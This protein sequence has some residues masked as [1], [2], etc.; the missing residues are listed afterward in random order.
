MKCSKL[1]I[2]LVSL[3]IYGFASADKAK[4]GTWSNYHLKGKV[5]TVKYII[6]STADNLVE[7]FVSDTTQYLINF[8]VKGDEIYDKKNSDSNKIILFD[9]NAPF[10]RERV[11]IMGGKT[12]FKYDK[13]KFLLEM[14][15]YS[16]DGKLKYTSKFKYDNM[17]E[18]I[19]QKVFTSRGE[20]KE[21]YSYEYHYDNTGNWTY[22]K[23][24]IPDKADK[25]TKREIEYFLD[26]KGK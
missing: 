20:L 12:I 1:I 21:T 5:K 14:N 17:G 26:L 16:E 6:Y 22:C 15:N 23:E 25:I 24:I 8:N 18:I 2:I 7:G 10:N 4:K 11:Q 9:Y 13:N 3:S 19:E